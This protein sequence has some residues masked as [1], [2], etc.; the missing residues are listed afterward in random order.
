MREEELER[1]I[2]KLN[3][4]IDYLTDNVFILLNKIS[5]KV[6]ADSDEAPIQP[7]INVPAP[8]AEWKIKAKGQDNE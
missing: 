1:Q 5:S 6:G 7:F 2:K 3:K 8:Q 4:K